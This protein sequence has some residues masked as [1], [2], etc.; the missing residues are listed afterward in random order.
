MRLIIPPYPSCFCTINKKIT[1][2]YWIQKANCWMSDSKTGLSCLFFF[3]PSVA[4]TW[5]GKWRRNLAASFSGSAGLSKS[6]CKRRTACANI[7]RHVMDQVVFAFVFQIIQQIFIGSDEKSSVHR[8]NCLCA[9][10]S[11]VNEAEQQLLEHFRSDVFIN[12][13]TLVY[14]AEMRWKSFR[15][16]FTR[17]ENSVIR[18]MAGTNLPL[19]SVGFPQVFKKR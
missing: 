17:K 10:S 8:L 1:R 12:R 11:R 6:P 3:H 15:A 13:L 14:I 7:G 2:F 5:F 19:G 18:I 9:N 16:A 4:M